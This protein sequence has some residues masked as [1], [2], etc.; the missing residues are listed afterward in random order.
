MQR[1]HVS[2]EEMTFRINSQR[3]SEEVEQYA[4]VIIDNSGS[5]EH[6]KMQIKENLKK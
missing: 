4:D 3:P 5:F 6:T 1:D 2:E